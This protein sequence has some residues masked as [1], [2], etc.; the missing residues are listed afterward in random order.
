MKKSSKYVDVYT[1]NKAVLV[2][3]TNT[4]KYEDDAFVDYDRTV[5]LK[6]RVGRDKDKLEFKEENAIAKFVETIDFE[7]PQTALDFNSGSG[8][9]DISKVKPVKKK[10]AHAAL[11]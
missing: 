5:T 7:D 3:V 10:K 8:T 11:N 1:P 2:T 9:T 6:I 4:P